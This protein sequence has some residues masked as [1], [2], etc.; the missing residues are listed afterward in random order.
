[1]VIYKGPAPAFDLER[2][3]EDRALSHTM[4]AEEESVEY[5]GDGRSVSRKDGQG[6]DV[7]VP[8]RRGRGDGGAVERMPAP[9]DPP[10][11]ADAP[12]R[13]ESVGDAVMM[14]ARFGQVG[15]D[16]ECGRLKTAT[17]RDIPPPPFPSMRCRTQGVRTPSWRSSPRSRR[18]GAGA[19]GAAARGCTAPPPPP[20]MDCAVKGEPWGREQRAA[21]RAD[22]EVAVMWDAGC[23]RR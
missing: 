11:F 5:N 14:A 4:T 9:V 17:M 12:R 10:D 16:T 2:A 23:T 1:M 6:R 19:E 21:R 3:G 15:H 8:V 20:H 7:D 18:H 22:V 13:R